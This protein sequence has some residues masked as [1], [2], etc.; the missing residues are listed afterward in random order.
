MIKTGVGEMPQ[1]PRSALKI[2]GGLFLAD[3][4]DDPQSPGL[5]HG[6]TGITTPAQPSTAHD[7]QAASTG[8]LR[9]PKSILSM[10]K[11]NAAARNKQR[12]GPGP[13][14]KTTKQSPCFNEYQLQPPAVRVELSGSRDLPRSKFE[15]DTKRGSLKLARAVAGGVRVQLTTTQSRVSLARCCSRQAQNA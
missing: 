5:H 14:T 3:G 11:P 9:V 12:P 2:C 8:T 10:L 6:E 13:K 7:H 4:S 1:A 15:E